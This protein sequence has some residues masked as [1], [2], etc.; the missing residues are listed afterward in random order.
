MLPGEALLSTP[1]DAGIGGGGGQTRQ[2]GDGNPIS[3]GLR[4]LRPWLAT[5]RGC[6]CFWKAF[7]VLGLCQPL[8]MLGEGDSACGKPPAR[9]E[10]PHPFSCMTRGVLQPWSRQDRWQDSL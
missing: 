10:D 2:E 9:L 5:S 8:T 7:K 3:V 1:F 4:H 6:H